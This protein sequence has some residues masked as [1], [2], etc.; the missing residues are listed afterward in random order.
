VTAAKRPNPTS[1][2]NCLSG[3]RQ[4]FSVQLSAYFA[5]P[6]PAVTYV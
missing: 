3:L 2:L 6:I 5:T 4:A 1:V